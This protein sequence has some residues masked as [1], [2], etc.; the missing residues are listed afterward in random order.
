M[1]A[2]LLAVLGAPGSGKGT[3]CAKIAV[4]HTFALHLSAGQL[5]RDARDAHHPLADSIA[6]TLARGGIVPGSWTAQLL[7]QRIKSVHNEYSWFII[8]GFPRNHDNVEALK[9]IQLE[10]RAEGN[11]LDLRG[12]L[13]IDIP[14]SE[15]ILRLGSRGREDDSAEIVLRRLELFNA[16]TAPVIDHYDSE[17]LLQR[18]GGVGSEE[19]VWKR[20]DWAFNN[21]IKAEKRD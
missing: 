5:L 3:Q 8:D 13:F 14:Q 2:N 9:A 15:A 12:V 18:V 16:V 19:E 11:A 10:A 17:G 7:Y 20:V 1:R 6:D 4:A 21:W